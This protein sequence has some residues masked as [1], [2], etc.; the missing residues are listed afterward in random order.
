MGTRAPR[1]R[2]LS[3]GTWEFRAGLEA[4]EKNAPR[5][6]RPPDSGSGLAPAPVHENCPDA[7]HFPVSGRGAEWGLLCVSSHSPHTA[8]TQIAHLVDPQPQ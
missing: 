8:V 1:S 3:P 6:R 7:S 5:A 4:A 2:P